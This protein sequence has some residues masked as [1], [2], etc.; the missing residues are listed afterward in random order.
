MPI[1]L[2][3][4]EFDPIGLAIDDDER[5]TVAVALFTVDATGREVE[6]GVGREV[7]EPLLPYP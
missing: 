1:G 3:S 4:E 6:T 2:I 5:D 7:Y